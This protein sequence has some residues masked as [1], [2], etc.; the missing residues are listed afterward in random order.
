MK[1][2]TR[3]SIYGILAVGIIFAGIWMAQA[4]VI[5]FFD[6]H[7]LVLVLGLLLVISLGGAGLRAVSDAF[8]DAFS[9]TTDSRNQSR[10]R[11][12]I[13]LFRMLDRSCLYISGFMIAGALIAILAHP[14]NKAIIGKGTSFGLLGLMYALLLRSLLFQPLLLAIRKK[15]VTAGE[16]TP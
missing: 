14:G 7:A 2:R 4:D 12:A 8:F 6:I 11:R 15:M 9:D 10:Y 1:M 3:F 13:A 5:M 16:D